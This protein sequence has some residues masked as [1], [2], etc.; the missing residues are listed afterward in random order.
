[1]RRIVAFALLSLLGAIPAAPQQNAALDKLPLGVRLTR[2]I[3]GTA[4]DR[5]AV[6]QTA[7]QFVK[8]VAMQTGSD[9]VLTLRDP[10][11]K[12]V[13]ESDLPNGAF[14][15]ETV[16]AIAQTAGEY[17][18][19]I[20]LA[21]SRTVK[22]S[23]QVTLAALH[24]ATPEDREELSAHQTLLQANQLR[25]KHAPDQ[26]REAVEL[27]NRIRPYFAKAGDRY[28][29]ALTVLM[30][31]AMLAEGGDIRPALSRSEESA[32][33][34]RQGSY[35]LGEAAALTNIGGM[36]DLLGEPQKALESYRQ[37]LALNRANGDRAGEANV[38]NNIGKVEGSV[39]D[40]QRSLD[41]YNLAL[42]LARQAGNIQYEG[43]LQH[44][45]GAAYLS[46]GNPEE[47]L[48]ELERALSLR[49]AAGDKSGEAVTLQLIAYAYGATKRPTK[50]QE[51]LEQA[52]ALNAAL[53]DRRAE[54]NVRRDLGRTYAKLGKL[55][56]AEA[57]LRKALELQRSV[58]DRRNTA[59]TLLELSRVMAL[60][61]QPEDSLEQAQQACAEFRA[62]GDRNSEAN[63]LE[64]IA[65][66][67]SDRGN[68]AAARDRLAEA[69]RLNEE[70]RTH[71]DSEQ[72]RASFFATRQDSYSFYIDVL[73]RLKDTGAALEANER[74]RARS[75]LD[76]LADA[77]VRTGVDPKL[78]ERER[79]ITNTLNAK[80]ARLLPLAATN[81]RAVA[82]QQ[83]IRDLESQ[84]QDVEAAIR[85]NSPGY[86]ALA[87]PS[88][89]KV[90]QIQQQLLDEDTLLLEYSLGEKRSYLWTVA[91]NDLH[92]WELPAR[93]MIEAE[94]EQ[95]TEL[96]TAR[97]VARRL[98]IPAERQKRIAEAD[99]SLAAAAR[100]LSR[101]V[102]GPAEG[103][104]GGKKLVIVPDGAL[105]RLPF[106]MLPI[107]GTAEP[108]IVSHE[109]VMLPSAS[110]LAVLRQEV[111]ARTPASKTLAV[112][113]D[114]VFD[115]TDPRAGKAHDSTPPQSSPEA[116]RILEHLADAGDGAS[117]G[118]KISRLPYTAQ[119]ADQILNV[120][121]SGANLKAVGFEA[122]RAAT[123]SGQLSDY[124]YLH[125]ATHGYLDTERP[126]LSALVL[127]QID[128]RNQPED[129]FLRV[130][131]IY[132]MRLTAELVVLSA[133]QT[134]LGKEVRGEGLM[135]LTRAFLYA[136]A[137]RVIVSLW[138]VNDRATADLM[139][140]LYRGM[141][142]EG[143]S[144][145]AA[146]RAAQLEM[147]K[148]KRWESPYYWAAFVQHGEW[149]SGSK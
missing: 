37:A 73:M 148:Q 46:L 67:E 40:W 1:M 105:Q 147:R 31:A 79:E 45:T 81:P 87:Q 60:K 48:N 107:G 137:P 138:N 54:A 86:A 104:L 30:Q 69:L 36:L 4:V 118:L 66:A 136:G 55:A 19:E 32:V 90:S 56:E 65:R 121:R 113:A 99:A 23:Y 94:V 41:N 68:L 61:G 110:A 93:G 108:L 116:T 63:A 88:P 132:N 92:A 129:G 25:K 33:L 142:R 13:M 131:D 14:G 78:I 126:S 76:M 101:M 127:S 50:A 24:E 100:E 102:I 74:S 62:I 15:P 44:N 38:L 103:V 51:Y 8:V 83:E 9:I 115:R 12:V 47:A 123:I 82:L 49:R 59:V 29:E 143:K 72:L 58:Q 64:T 42:E 35:P 135:G 141:L 149:K 22:D 134:G 146:L 7:G 122:N 43:L 5:F 80:G 84:Y 85:K 11:Q 57:S 120:A 91:K 140:S 21:G 27:L 112:F 98:E 3:E 2:R 52:L 34:F 111:S 28:H 97:S 133:C 75:M 144:P 125:F 53:G 114:P 26:R 10:Q 124:R 109:V 128:E 106:S 77:D 95:V 117:A 130:N 39:G 18:V 89:L 71:A 6:S 96:L 16:E 119:E 17:V 145:S 139:T 70:N 20:K